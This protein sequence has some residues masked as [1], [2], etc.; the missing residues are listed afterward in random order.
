MGLIERRG[1]SLVVRDMER[2]ERMID[3]VKAPSD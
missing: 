1:K 3:E 2:L